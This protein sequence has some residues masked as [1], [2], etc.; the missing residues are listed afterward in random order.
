MKTLMRLAVFLVSAGA[1]FA[2]G[3]YTSRIL[4]SAAREAAATN[5]LY[6]AGDRIREGRNANAIFLVGSAAATNPSTFVLLA[7][8][9]ILIDAKEPSLAGP[10]LEQALTEAKLSDPKLEN[11]IKRSL[12]RA[13]VKQ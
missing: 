11:A 10:L 12:E 3:V 9:D 4:D 1:C 8:G 2:G 13:I 7:A 6:Q 5:L